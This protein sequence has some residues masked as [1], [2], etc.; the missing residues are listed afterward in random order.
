MNRLH[1]RDSSVRPRFGLLTARSALT[2]AGV[3]ALCL[4]LPSAASAQ[5]VLPDPIDVDPYP[6]L[7]CP[8]RATTTLDFPA[9]ISLVGPMLNSVSWSRVGNTFDIRIK[10][11][12]EH[13]YAGSNQNSESCYYE[14]GL[15]TS[16][17]RSIN[18]SSVTPE[19]FGPEVPS[20]A[21]AL[22]TVIDPTYPTRY[23]FNM[24]YQENV[25]TFSLDYRPMR[26]KKLCVDLPTANGA[27]SGDA[28]VRNCSQ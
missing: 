20:T 24:K 25:G 2:A 9:I 17:T 21:H 5:W 23:S 11:R 28:P 22:V 27:T 7:S 12:Q 4:F 26:K 6:G 1:A 3:A 13:R 19:R 8:D 14:D 18:V 15:F 10:L 16:F